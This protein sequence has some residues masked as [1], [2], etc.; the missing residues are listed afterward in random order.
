MHPAALEATVAAMAGHVANPHSAEHAEGWRSADAVDAAR[1]EVAAAI[2]ADPD[3][4]VFVSGATEAN[5]LALLGCTR[6]GGDRRRVVVSAIE[7]RAVLGPARE[8]ARRGMELVIAPV[9]HDGVVDLDALADLVDDRT[10]LVSVM[11]VNN[12]IGTVQ[13]VASIAAICSRAGALLH[14]DA[15]QALAWL[16]VDAYSLGADLLS[17]SGHKM[18][19]PKGVGALFVARHVRPLLAPLLF[20]GEQEDG[21]RPG[22]LATP[23]CVGFGAACR[24]LPDVVEVAAWRA[25]TGRL[26]AGLLDLAPG[27]WV[28]G[29]R[30]ERHPGSISLT[31]PGI[32]AERLV[33]RMQPAV[34]LS[35]GSACTSGIPEPSHVL[36]AIG[37]TASECEATVR[38][39]P[40]RFTTDVEIGRAIRAFREAVAELCYLERA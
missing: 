34:A 1:A 20:G 2:G 30:A 35:R 38:L 23:L 7:H 36:A 4:V 29:A 31:L 18:G 6:P 11:L 9:T 27:A 19:G 26:E 10:L 32:D 17:V 14:V 8:L 24:T 25:R 12:E 3:E 39:S 21:L 33:A 5:N 40:G 13:L 15:A 16:P 22:T 28:N 37:L